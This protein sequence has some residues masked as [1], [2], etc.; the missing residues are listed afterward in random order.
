MRFRRRPTE[1][2]LQS[3]LVDGAPA[4]VERWLDDPD[5]TDQLERLTALP[6]EHSE[7]LRDTVA[8]TDGF[9]DRT[10]DG[11]RARVSDLERLG[12]IVGLLG[13]GP[14]TARTWIDHHRD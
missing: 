3:W 11:V 14:R 12:V 4:S 8:P 9:H 1:A 2:Q 10:T 13:L 5:I 6:D 7:A